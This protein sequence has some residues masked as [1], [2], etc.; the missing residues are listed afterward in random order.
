MSDQTMQVKKPFW[1]RGLAGFLDFL[2]IF[3]VSGYVIGAL[4]GETTPD[5]FHLTGL[6]ALACF[7]IVVIYFYLGW[8]RLGGTIWQRILSAR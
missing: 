7:A 5:G 2:T 4:T 1:R 8:N 6:A 3:F